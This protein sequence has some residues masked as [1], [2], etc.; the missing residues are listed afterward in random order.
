MARPSGNPGEAAQATAQ[1]QEAVD[2]LEKA[3]PGLPVGHPIHK[4]VTSA[5]S[6]LSKHAPPGSASPGLGLQAM[7]QALMDKMKSSPMAALL[8]AKGAPGADGGMGGGAGGAGGG[9]MGMP[10]SNPPPSPGAQMG[11]APPGGM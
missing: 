9:G 6:S 7:K 5:I 4:A 3:L 8:A 2:L 10:M 1:V 11:G